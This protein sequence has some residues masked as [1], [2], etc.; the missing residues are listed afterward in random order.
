M[1]VYDP[2]D[3]SHIKDVD[4][5]VI[6]HDPYNL[7]TS[8][9]TGYFNI[10][11]NMFAA[12]WLSPIPINLRSDLGGDYLTGSARFASINSRWSLGPS[13]YSFNKSNLLNVAPGGVVQTTKLQRYPL[14]KRLWWQLPNANN[15]N[16]SGGHRFTDPNC[17]S[18]KI[19]HDTPANYNWKQECVLENDLWTEVSRAS[20]GTIIPGSKTYLTLGRIG[21]VRKGLAYKIFPINGGPQPSSG[22]YPYDATDW[23]NYIWLFD[24]QDMI[25][26]KNGLTE[27][28]DAMPY[29]YG[30]LALPFED[31]DGNGQPALIASAD[32]D[33]K[34]NRLYIVL[35][36]ADPLTNHYEPTPIVLVY[37]LL[38]NRPKPPILHIKQIE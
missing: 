2:Y 23:D 8:E 7:K 27:E 34:N 6:V 11:G 36:H 16:Y 37:E 33:E 9:V 13:A 3:A 24:V 14:N 28:H 26:H 12:G 30:K 18:W 21:G 32:Y 10:E 1:T 17:P 29:E 22:E 31:L 19:D 20:Y 15:W 25:D 38:I 5:M 35:G 4:N